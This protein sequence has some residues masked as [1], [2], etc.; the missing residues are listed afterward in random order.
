LRILGV[1]DSRKVDAN[2][3]IACYGWIDGNP[4]HFLTSAD[5]I[6]MNEVTRR[7]GRCKKNGKAPICIKRYN[8]GMQA[9]DR[10]DQ[11]R[12]TFSFASQHGFKKYYV[13]IILRLMD[14]SGVD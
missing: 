5:G 10:H 4:V 3:G 12:P 1:P 2:Y 9:V 6:T 8:K 14:K 13:K 11:L 7:I